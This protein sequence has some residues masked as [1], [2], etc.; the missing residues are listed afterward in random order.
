MYMVTFFLNHF[1]IQEKDIVQVDLV[2]F[3]V[4]K[5]RRRYFCVVQFFSLIV[6]RIVGPPFMFVFIFISNYTSGWEVFSCLTEN[7][8]NICYVAQLEPALLPRLNLK[9]VLGGVAVMGQGWTFHMSSPEEIRHWSTFTVTVP[10]EG[11]GIAWNL[12]KCHPELH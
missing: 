7:P 11:E 10:R 5:F 8:V 3:F 9:S 1:L 12:P 4:L 2:Y 6:T